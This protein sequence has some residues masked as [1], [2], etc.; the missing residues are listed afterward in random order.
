MDAE[1]DALSVELQALAEGLKRFG[2]LEAAMRVRALGEIAE[3]QDTDAL[4]ALV[5]QATQAVAH[6]A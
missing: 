2:A 4:L 6:A 5:A 1:L 3:S